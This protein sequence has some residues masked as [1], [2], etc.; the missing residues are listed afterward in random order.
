[1]VHEL[2][3]SLPVM[4][5]IAHHID[6]ESRYQQVVDLKILILGPKLLFINEVT[7]SAIKK[8]DPVSRFF[9][10]YNMRYSAYKYFSQLHSYLYHKIVIVYIFITK[11]SK[12]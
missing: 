8:K 11:T 3:F 10:T 4:L 9:R 6:N 1:M 2:L 5:E 12:S 7:I